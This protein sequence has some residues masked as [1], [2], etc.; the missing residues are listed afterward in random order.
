MKNL[1]E[2]SPADDAEFKTINS[3]SVTF[4]Y[5]VIFQT[6]LYNIDI[7]KAGFNLILVYDTVVVV[8]V[9]LGYDF[10][11]AV[12][13]GANIWIWQSITFSKKIDGLVLIFIL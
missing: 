10:L 3:A 7:I 5:S 13:P 12:I 9:L 2:G 8:T 11:T 1:S 6:Q 4:G